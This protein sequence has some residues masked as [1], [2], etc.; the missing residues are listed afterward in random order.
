MPTFGAKI[1]P[2]KSEHKMVDKD[3][4]RFYKKGVNLIDINQ[5]SLI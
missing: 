4:F 5:S 1:Q 2:L 3:R